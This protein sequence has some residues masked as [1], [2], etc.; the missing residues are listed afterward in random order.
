MTLDRD[1]RI[2]VNIPEYP[3]Y[4]LHFPGY[5]ADKKLESVKQ[6][7]LSLVVETSAFFFL[8]EEHHKNS[9]HLSK[10]YA[11]FQNQFLT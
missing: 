1:T 9:N 7:V 11:K 10:L 6:S 3:Q 5:R 4:A 2:T 8:R